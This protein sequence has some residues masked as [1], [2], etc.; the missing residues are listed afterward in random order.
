MTAPDITPLIAYA[1]AWTP[2]TSG[3]VTGKC[4]RA[5]V[6]KKEDF[7]KYRGKLAGMIVI[8]GPDAE[9]KPIEEAPF[10]RLSS[11]DLAKIGEYEIPGEHPPFRLSEMLRRRQFMKD[12]NQFFADEQT[13]RNHDRSATYHGFRTV[14]PDCATAR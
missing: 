12:V 9:V 1:K 7:D 6:D 2:G 14:E 13:G 10:K 5:T 11:D 4:V 3:T 8:L